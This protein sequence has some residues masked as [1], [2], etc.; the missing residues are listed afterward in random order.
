MKLY[1]TLSRKTE[2]FKPI[3]P[4][5]VGLY[6][7]G[8]TVYEHTHLG[9][10]RMY[11]SVDLLVRTLRYFDYQV[12]WVMNIT[13]VGH[14]TGDRDM[15]E[16]KLEKS[17]REKG[18][19]IWQITQRYTAEFWRVMESVNVGKP[20]VIAKATDHIEEMM[21]MVC[22][23]DKKGYTYRTSDGVYFDTSK[24]K[25]YGRLA[26]VDLKGLQAGARVEINPEKRHPADFALWKLA[27][28]GQKRQM[29][30]DSP[31][32]KH[33]FPGWHIECSAMSRKYLGD[34]FDI[35]T[36]GEDHIN[37]HHTNE[38]AQTEAAVGKL[39][40]RYWFHQRFLQVNDR[41][42][43]KSTGNF[44]TLDQIVAK[45]YEPMAL[46]YLFLTG[47]Y[48]RK[49]NFTFRALDSA[50]AAYQ[51]LFRLVG[52]MR[53]GLENKSQ[54][55]RFTL[56]EVKRGQVDE[57]QARFDI[58]IAN[59]INTP[60]AVAVM[61]EMLGSNISNFDKYDLLRSWDRVLGLKIDKMQS[62]VEPKI[63]VT[64]KQLVVQ[65]NKAR[66]AGE[67]NKADK[68]RRQINAA[69]YVVRDGPDGVTKVTLSFEANKMNLG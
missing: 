49:T 61:W 18:K 67:Y 4:P 46:R 32:G 40:A 58:E 54:P 41:K 63:P 16:D 28:K 10:V 29:E 15:G 30:W 5:K 56:D 52:G 24:L 43:S 42:M 14:L 19:D 3:N 36:G 38:L 69:G 51:K 23:L 33:S 17:A 35:H 47:H 37:V 11:I 45:G 66:F 2:E 9:H 27:P 59:D 25:S 57:F 20:D 53:A 7:C 60:R 65:R 34:E 21:A 48:R 6:S 62:G 64:I 26:E 55:Q 1:N 68:L 39:Q 44:Y 31:W 22:K 12:N 50:Q 13:D 8:P